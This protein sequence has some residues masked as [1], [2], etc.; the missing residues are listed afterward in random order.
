MLTSCKLCSLLQSS[1]WWCFSGAG[2]LCSGCNQGLGN[3]KDDAAR[4]RAAADYVE[5]H[6]W[7]KVLEAP[8]VFRMVPPREPAGT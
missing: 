8:G 6:S 4:V 2:L 3:F 5:R 7:Q 1:Y